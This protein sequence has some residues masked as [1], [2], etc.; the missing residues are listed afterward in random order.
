MIEWLEVSLNLSGSKMRKISIVS[1]ELTLEYPPQGWGTTPGPESGV[2]TY[3]EVARY[4]R[5][6]FMKYNPA[7]M[8]SKIWP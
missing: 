2:I 8:G 7:V 5:T 1:P 6:V 4:V 3:L